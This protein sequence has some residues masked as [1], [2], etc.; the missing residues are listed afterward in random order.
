MKYTMSYP[1][2]PVW[3]S[4]ERADKLIAKEEEQLLEKVSTLSF[5]PG[6]AAGTIVICQPWGSAGLGSRVA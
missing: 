6:G 4:R 2:R 3:I 1:L 5:S